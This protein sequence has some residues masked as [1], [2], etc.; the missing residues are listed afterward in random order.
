MSL[1]SYIFK[2]KHGAEVSKK[3]IQ[4]FC[5]D[6]LSFGVEGL[7]L[8]WRDPLPSGRH[9]VPEGYLEFHV[10]QEGPVEYF[11]EACHHDAELTASQLAEDLYIL[12]GDDFWYDDLASGGKSYTFEDRELSEIVEALCEPGSRMVSFG[13]GREVYA[14][15]INSD[16]KYSRKHVDMLDYALTVPIVKESQQEQLQLTL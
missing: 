2:P 13:S 6:F 10:D 7:Y 5:S 4:A 12:L 14:V 9:S 8:W 15:D 16:G 3:V 11:S 1:T